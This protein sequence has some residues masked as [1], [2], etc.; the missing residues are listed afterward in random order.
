MNENIIATPPSYPGTL[1]AVVPGG[2]AIDATISKYVRGVVNPI[3]RETI[4]TLLVINSKFRDNYSESTTDFGVELNDP[5]NDV[6]ALKLS[7]L[8]LLNSYYSFSEYLGTNSFIITTYQYNLSDTTERIDVQP[9]KV[10]LPE[11][12]YSAQ[13]LVAALQDLLAPATA[14]PSA[15]PPF[16]NLAIVSAHYNPAKGKIYFHLASP[17][18]VGSCATPGYA[19][20]FDLDFGATH[21]CPTRSIYSNFGWLVGFRK[22]Q[23]SFLEDYKKDLSTS[24]PDPVFELGYNPEAFVNVIGTH[25]YLLEVN[26]YNKN[27]SEVL[28]YNTSHAYSFNIHDILAKVPNVAEQVDLIF[29]DSSDKIFKTKQYFGPVTIKKLHFR[30]LDE[31]GNVVDLNR[32]DMTISLEVEQLNSSYKI[33]T[34]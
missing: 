26:D 29:E 12:N 8:E 24:P 1:P 6:V 3:K 19:R 20:A 18:P 30:L 11:G 4:K 5:L 21:D 28:R 17:M 14:D 27:V 15:L 16:P 10:V 33:M 13:E 31:Y 9:T 23:Y 2:S 7:S 22:V 25:Y 32:A 34:Q